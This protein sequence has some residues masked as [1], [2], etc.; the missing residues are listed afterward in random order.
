MRARP[1]LSGEQL[2]QA[3]LHRVAAAARHLPKGARI[4]FVGRTKAQI[5]RQIGADGSADL[6]KVAKVLTDLG[7]PEELVRAE[8]L[9]IDSKWL[10]NRGRDD[11]AAATVVPTNSPR[12]Y[13]PLRSRWKPATPATRTLPHD[14]DT[15]EDDDD[16][17]TGTVL[18]RPDATAPAPWPGDLDA[19]MPP[20][21]VEDEGRRRRPPREGPTPLDGVWDLARGHKLESVAVVVLGLGGLILP[22]PF[23]P[24]G[25]LVAT[26]SRLFDGRDKVVAWLGA[27]LF[28]L[29][30][31][32]VTALFVGGKQNPVMI[33]TNALAADFGLLVRFGCVLSAVYLAWRVRKGRRV[34][35]PPWKR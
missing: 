19:I 10:K 14:A 13:R 25:A 8:R 28:A 32:V 16:A 11:E 1:N 27:P 7:E 26:F 17:L 24:A 21:P 12:V 33:Y 15:G 2:V 18:N 6:G 9:R 22:F 20:G 5:D 31:S 23:W 35:I 3:Y 34:K 4:A 30:G 29:V